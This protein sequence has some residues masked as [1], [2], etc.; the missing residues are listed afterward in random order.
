MY[1]LNMKL[2]QSMEEMLYEPE[3]IVDKNQMAE[4]PDVS[5][6]LCLA[7]YLQKLLT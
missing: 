2:F 4:F 5:L 3:Y 6:L 7:R 1:N